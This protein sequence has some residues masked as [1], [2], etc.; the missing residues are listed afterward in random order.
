MKKKIKRKENRI[1]TKGMITNGFMFEIA[2]SPLNGIDIFPD[3]TFRCNNV[4]CIAM[5]LHMSRDG[6]IQNLT[7]LINYYWLLLI[8]RSTSISNERG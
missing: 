2:F 8:T 4:V 7:N 6:V 1:I 5:T 3:I